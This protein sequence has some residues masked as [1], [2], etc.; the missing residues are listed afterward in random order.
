MDV[1]VA[2]GARFTDLSEF[3]AV[4]FPM[5]IKAGSGL[6]GLS[7]DKGRAVVPFDGEQGGGESKFGMALRAIGRGG[8]GGELL[9]VVVRMAVG[10]ACMFQRARVPILV[11]GGAGDRFMLSFQGEAGCRMLEVPG[12]FYLVE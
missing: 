1:L 11:T 5:A 3:P 10:A 4:A 2:V 8:P 7:K 12:R 9:P 6:V